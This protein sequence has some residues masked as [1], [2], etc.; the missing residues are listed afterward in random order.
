MSY[1]TDNKTYHQQI[2]ELDICNGNYNENE[3]MKNVY[4]NVNY[5]KLI[6]K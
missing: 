2:L 3:E 1:Q 6:E 5:A 4:K